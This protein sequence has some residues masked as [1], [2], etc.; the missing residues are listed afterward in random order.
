MKRADERREPDNELMGGVGASL[1]GWPGNQGTRQPVALLRESA[2][3]WVK[4]R[5]NSGA[6]DSRERPA[7]FLPLA[8]RQCSPQWPAHIAARHPRKVER[9]T[10]PRAS[11]FGDLTT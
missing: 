2:A 8:L 3:R 11:R 9:R 7:T 4:Y 10:G 1:N 5:E 6:D